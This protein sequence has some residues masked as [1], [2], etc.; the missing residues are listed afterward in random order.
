VALAVVS[1]MKNLAITRAW[2]T[3]EV[4]AADPETARLL[5]IPIDAP[6]AKARVVVRGR[7]NIVLYVGEIT[8]RGDCVRISI[9]LTDAQR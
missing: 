4:A 5:N 7:D 2:Q 3:L 1:T 8:Y 6:I 9:E